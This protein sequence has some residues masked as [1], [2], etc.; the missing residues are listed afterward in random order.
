[1]M[2]RITHDAAQ[3]G[4]RHRVFAGISKFERI[5]MPPIVSKVWV[6]I[7]DVTK[8]GAADISQ[9][10]PFEHLAAPDRRM[11]PVRLDDGFC[12]EPVRWTAMRRRD[13]NIQTGRRNGH[14]QHS[15]GILASQGVPAAKR[16]VAA[17]ARVSTPAQPD[18]SASGP[19]HS[20]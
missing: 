14:E 12:N 11:P 20:R 3:N 7:A 8:L 10:L 19:E 15:R 4:T 17:G 5:A 9:R 6:R 1:M 16:Q 13:D 18:R 2:P